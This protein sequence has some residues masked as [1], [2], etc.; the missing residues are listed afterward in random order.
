MVEK[1]RHIQT[2]PYIE[3]AEI[4][5]RSWIEANIGKF[6]FSAREFCS[7]KLAKE[8]DKGLSRNKAA[9]VAPYDIQLRLYEE[10]PICELWGSF[11]LEDSIP[12]GFRIV[13]GSVYIEVDEFLDDLY[14]TRRV[15]HHYLE[16]R[17][18]S[19]LIL[20]HCPGQFYKRRAE[21][22]AKGTRL[23]SLI[24]RAP[25]LTSAFTSPLGDTH[26]FLIASRAAIKNNL[27]LRYDTQ[28]RTGD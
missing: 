20:D 2:A 9:N 26:T 22:V 15:D 3:S 12:E 28:P 8:W 13:F 25:G 23:A 16:A 27:G 11:W 19:G 6:L 7:L 21:D 18:G 10:M 24:E 4:R 1:Y 14:Q 17:D 5:A